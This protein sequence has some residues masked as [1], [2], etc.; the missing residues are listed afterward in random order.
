MGFGVERKR[1]QLARK[2][3]VIAENTSFRAQVF[4]VAIH[5]KLTML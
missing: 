2:R 1:V 4:A 3:L 5:T